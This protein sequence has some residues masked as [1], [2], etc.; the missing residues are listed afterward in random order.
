MY[1]PCRSTIGGDRALTP[2]SRHSLGRPLPYQL[3]DSPQA[4][5]G[6]PYG[7]YPAQI[8]G[9]Q[10]YVLTYLYIYVTIPAKEGFMQTCTKLVR[11]V[12]AVTLLVL[13]GAFCVSLFAHLLMAVWPNAVFQ[14]LPVEK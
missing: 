8:F 6:A 9:G 12:L 13:F 5:L 11:I 2:P 3:A 4:V 7:I 14:N 10:Y 1:G